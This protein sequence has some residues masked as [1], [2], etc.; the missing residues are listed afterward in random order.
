MGEMAPPGLAADRAKA[1]ALKLMRLPDARAE[2]PKN[3]EM[4]EQV[5]ILMQ[6]MEA[7]A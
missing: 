6:S 1:E 7:A 2:L 3:P 5:R 4:L